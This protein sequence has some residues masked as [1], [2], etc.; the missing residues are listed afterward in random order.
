MC[1]INSPKVMD[2]GWGRKPYWSGGIASATAIES[3]LRAP[4][5]LEYSPA[6][7]TGPLRHPQQSAKTEAQQREREQP[8]IAYDFHGE[9]LSEASIANW[10]ECGGVFSKSEDLLS[11][12]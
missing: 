1:V 7:S 6:H 10:R 12:F 8:E 4:K 3:L 5:R 11:P 2:S 9:F